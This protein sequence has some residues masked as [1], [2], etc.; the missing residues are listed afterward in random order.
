VDD[1]N[2]RCDIHV[3]SG[4]RDVHVQHQTWIEGACLGHLHVVHLSRRSGSAE[5]PDVTGTQ[6]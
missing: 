6:E 2:E 4:L 1:E 3:A 5:H